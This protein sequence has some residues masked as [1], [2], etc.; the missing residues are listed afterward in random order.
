M[1]Q[2]LKCHKISNVKFHEMSNVMKCQSSSNGKCQM[3]LELFT[4]FDFFGATFGIFWHLLATFAI[5]LQLLPFFLQLL[6]SFPFL[7]CF[8]ETFA[9]FHN[10]WLL[11][12]KIK[13]WC[14]SLCAEGAMADLRST[15]HSPDNPPFFAFLSFSCIY[16]CC[17]SMCSMGSM[18]AQ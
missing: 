11:L 15:L 14:N 10:F 2:N 7:G 4:A 9:T 3:F 6:V 16:V 8:L 17:G 5:F 12:G 13:K 18:W 1:S